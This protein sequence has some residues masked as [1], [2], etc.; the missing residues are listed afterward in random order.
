MAA[1]VVAWGVLG[2]IEELSAV[3]AA[4]LALDLTVATL[5][6]RRRLLDWGR[7][8]LWLRALPSVVA[9]GASFRLASLEGTSWALGPT[10]LFCAATAWTVTSLAWLGRSFALLP[11]RA[12]LRTT[13][14]YAL[15]RHPAYLG[16]MAMVAACVWAAPGWAT[17]LC[18]AALI[19]AMGWRVLAEERLMADN[20]AHEAYRAR[21]RWRLLPWLW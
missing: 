9:A 13:G 1:S 16:E 14:P 15:L 5:L 20:P 19:P 6:L 4:L 11:A 3:R 17:G 18:G 2:L 12:E 10:V 8:G 21:V 7:P